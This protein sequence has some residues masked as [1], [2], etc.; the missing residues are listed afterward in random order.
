LERYAIFGGSFDPPHLCHERA[1]AT[2]LKNFEVEK[3]FIIP[4]FISPF[5]TTFAAPAE[6]RFEWLQKVFAK[7]EKIEVLD[8]EIKKK[9]SV[10]TIDTVKELHVKLGKQ[11]YA[12]IFL[13]MGLDNAREFHKWHGHDEL[14]KMV[15]PIVI[16][17]GSEKIDDF[18]AI[19]FECPYSSTM[20]RQKPSEEMICE[21]IREEVMSFYKGIDK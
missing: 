10:Y 1:V 12:K 15:E 17:R 6:L 19:S 7:Y 11:E 3:L 2:F 13:I 21:E 5:K 8:V 14:L 16:N 20:F 4:T 18:F 9:K